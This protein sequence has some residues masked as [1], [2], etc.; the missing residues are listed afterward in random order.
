M[1]D[2]T[3][4]DL[5]RYLTLSRA[6]VR[7]ATALRLDELPLETFDA[8]TRFAVFWQRLYG[9]GDVP[10]G[11][12]R[13]QAQM[14]ELRIDDVRGPLLTESKS[15]FKLRFDEPEHLNERSSTFE[16][17]RA[18]AAAWDRGATEAVA[19]TIAIAERQ[20]T[21]AHLWAVVGE[22]IRQLPPSDSV[23]KALTA[24]QRNSGT[25]G[26]LVQRVVV[27]EQASTDQLSLPFTTEELRS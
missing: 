15:G 3:T 21:D 1:P 26:T 23:T 14:D 17:V 16:V 13:F 9:R 2:G 5:D 18:M 7:D 11:E 10:K 22:F 25:I 27:T 6:A 4:A 20:P 12:A 24:I 8:P 19:T